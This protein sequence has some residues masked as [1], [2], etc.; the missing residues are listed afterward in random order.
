L[1]FE[2]E[3]KNVHASDAG[4]QLDLK[5]ETIIFLM[6]VAFHTLFGL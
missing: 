3:N 4:Q 2:L 5:K 1:I 6:V